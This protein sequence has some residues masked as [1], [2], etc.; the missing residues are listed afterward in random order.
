MEEE[1]FLEKHLNI[2]LKLVLGLMFLIEL[3]LISTLALVVGI[4]AQVGLSIGIFI[5]IWCFREIGQSFRVMFGHYP[6]WWIIR[7]NKSKPSVAGG[8][9][10]GCSDDE[11]RDC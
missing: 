4:E 7:L 10:S 2:Q 9:M 3:L 11:P 8:W 1:S 6:T 5:P